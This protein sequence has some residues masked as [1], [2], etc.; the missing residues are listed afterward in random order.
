[1][2]GC[3]PTGAVNACEDYESLSHQPNF[4][5]YPRNIKPEQALQRFDGLAA[6]TTQHFH[7]SFISSI[8]QPVHADRPS[9]G[10][11]EDFSIHM[12]G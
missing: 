6:D 5:L 9:G 2:D 10:P 11:P 7:P 4:R 12:V 8:E 3:K 1:L